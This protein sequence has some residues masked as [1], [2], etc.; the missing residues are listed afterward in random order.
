MPHT[1][2]APRGTLA[3]ERARAQRRRRRSRVRHENVT[4][5]PAADLLT[6]ATGFHMRITA[7]PWEFHGESA[8]LKVNQSHWRQVC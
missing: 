6:V 3:I 7:V 8:A 2:G 5:H 1:P 4:W